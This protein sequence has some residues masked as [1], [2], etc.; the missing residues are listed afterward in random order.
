MKELEEVL[1]LLRAAVDYLKVRKD[2]I[3]SR[4]LYT[5][6]QELLEEL[7]KDMVSPVGVLVR[8]GRPVIRQR[9]MHEKSLQ[10]KFEV[11]LAF[12]SQTIEH[13]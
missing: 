7:G 13:A 6:A 10:M 9:L 2:P 12:W 5:M 3:T 11:A 4:A 8:K 1:R